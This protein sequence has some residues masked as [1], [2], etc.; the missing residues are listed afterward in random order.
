MTHTEYRKAVLA[1]LADHNKNDDYS[2]SCGWKPKSEN[3][4][5][6]SYNRHMTTVIRKAGLP[7]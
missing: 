6:S 1:V 5:S 4:R 7:A 3:Q 2:C